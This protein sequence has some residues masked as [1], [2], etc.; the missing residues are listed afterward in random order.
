[1]MPINNLSLT[2][3]EPL[4]KWRVLDV[5]SLIKECPQRPEYFN[6]CKTMRKLE[7]QNIIQ[8]FRHPF[9][10]KK[11]LYLTHL[12]EESLTLTDNPTSISKETLLHDIKVSEIVKILMEAGIFYEASL[13]HELHNKKNFKVSYKIIPDALL[14]TKRQGIDV[15]VALEVELSRK[16]IPRIVEK[17]RQ[18]MNSSLYH[19][20]IYFFNKKLHLDRY[21]E[22]LLEKIG[23]EIEQRFFFFA[24]ETLATSR[25]GVLSSR[26]FFKGNPIVLGEVFKGK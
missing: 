26:G 6:F 23:P 18:Y 14:V 15:K 24:D 16:S 22:L 12:G 11:Y 2:Y 19:Y 1:M 3:L 13:E 21:R 25:E 7:K 20:V 17:A 10:R 4:L 8:S 5:Q 9:S